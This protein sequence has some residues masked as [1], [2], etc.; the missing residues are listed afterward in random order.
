VSTINFTPNQV[1]TNNA[2]V[3]LG[4]SGRISVQCTMPAGSTHF[5]LDVTGYF[6]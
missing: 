1:R 5:V 6:K 4:S 2:M 3:P